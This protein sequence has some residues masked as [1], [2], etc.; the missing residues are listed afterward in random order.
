MEITGT[1]GWDYVV[2]RECGHRSVRVDRHVEKHGM[3]IW[4]YREKH[5]ADSPIR[6]GKMVAHMAAVHV[7]K[8]L[9]KPVTAWKETKEYP[10][11]L[12]SRLHTVGKS[13]GG[14]H[15]MRCPECK[16]TALK[17]TEIKMWAGKQEGL[18]YLVCLD[19]G[20][21]AQNLASH[22]TTKHPLYHLR[23]TDAPVV[24]ELSMIRDNPLVGNVLSEYTKELMRKN[25][26]AWARG[27]TKE[28]DSRI[29][30]AALK[31]KGKIP[32]SKGLTK[33]THS[34]LMSTSENM[35]FYVGENRHWSAPK[36]NLTATDFEPYLDADGKLDMW[37]A[38]DGIGANPITIRK[39]LKAAGGT[40]S[41]MHVKALHE[42]MHIRI[43]K[44]DLLPYARKDGKIN[45]GAAMLGL[46]QSARIIRSECLRHGLEVVPRRIHQTMCLTAIATVLGGSAFVEEWSH[47]LFRNKNTGCRF[48]YGGYYSDCNLIIEYHGPQHYMFPNAYMRD[49]SYRPTW[50][51]MCWR[52]QEKE[53][54]V[55]VAGM[56]YLA[57]RAD[58]PF[59]NTEYLTKRLQEIGVLK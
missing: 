52:D 27:L 45:T 4:T 55:K 9:S 56:Y 57:V 24:A 58:E 41:D 31:M 34:S 46:A 7:T 6:C 18:D 30:A 8:Q 19:C 15:D 10:C 17:E 23:H 39:Y 13:M 48:L 25:A 1:E 12:C 5:G 33:F 36:L 29:A 35:K 54:L 28:T 50:E 43:P 44:S 42:R 14:T 2:C 20:Y 21:K 22:I 49:E 16:E 3:T 53:R 26:G 38:E 32:W 11:P 59:T 40:L 37:A 47:N 51:D